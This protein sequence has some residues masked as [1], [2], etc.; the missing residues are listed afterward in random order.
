MISVANST[1]YIYIYF[2]FFFRSAPVAYGGSQA[3]GPIRAV[4]TGLHHSH[5]NTRSEPCLWPTSQ[6]MATPDPQP[7]EWGQGSNPRPHGCYSGSLTTE[8]WWKLPYQIFKEEIISVLSRNFVGSAKTQYQRL[9]RKK[10][11]KIPGHYPHENQKKK[12]FKNSTKF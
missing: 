10:K 3:S 5:S 12:K 6:Q 1:K 7:T 2:A 4:A 11:K 8:P 9:T